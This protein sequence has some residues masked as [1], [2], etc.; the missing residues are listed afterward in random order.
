MEAD[1]DDT[2]GW[3]PKPPPAFSL[4]RMLKPELREEEEDDVDVVGGEMAC[5]QSQGLSSC[6]LPY[7]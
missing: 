1:V 3:S 5:S 4:A 7:R 6:P 2:G